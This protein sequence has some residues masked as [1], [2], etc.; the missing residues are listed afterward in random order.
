MALVVNLNPC[1]ERICKQLSI[2]LQISLKSNNQ[3]VH[4]FI[5][6]YSS[7]PETNRFLFK[8]GSMWTW[9]CRK[10]WLMA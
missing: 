6:L 7:L 9:R 2:L 5:F 10:R 8:F 4:S 3:K 1:C